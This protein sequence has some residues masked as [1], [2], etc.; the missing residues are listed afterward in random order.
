[1]DL[2]ITHVHKGLMRPV[3]SVG[4]S[5]GVNSSYVSTIRSGPFHA[6]PVAVFN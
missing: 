6:S 2:L 3:L 4:G 5:G 1:M